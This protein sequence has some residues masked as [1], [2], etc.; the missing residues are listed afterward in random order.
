MFHLMNMI[1]KGTIFGGMVVAGSY[2]GYGDQFAYA[3]I[4]IFGA[5]PFVA[6]MFGLGIT[7]SLTID[8][9]H[10]M[11]IP[12]VG[13]RH[14]GQD[15]SSLMLGAAAGAAVMAGGLY[16]IA[17]ELLRDYGFARA[18]MIGAGSEVAGS[19]LYNMLVG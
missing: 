3:N 9:L 11:V 4:P 1:E 19:L 16:M 5:I 8:I 2:I 13:I 6:F 15:Q 12:E 10:T 17:P 14:K 18:A 7:T